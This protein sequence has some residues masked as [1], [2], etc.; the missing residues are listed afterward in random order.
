MAK[1]MI[2]RRCEAER[3]R[4]DRYE[5]TLR[6]AQRAPRP[7]PD[8]AR[9]LR[10]SA[11]GFAGILARDP[12]AWRPKL[13][14]RDPARLRL[15][16]ARHLFALYSVPYALE[17]I[18]LDGSGLDA[19][20]ITLRRRWYVVAARG[21][22]LWKEEAKEWLSRKEVHW[23][24][25][26][27]G[28]LGFD[29][30]IWLAVAR[31]YTEDIGV[32]LR[33]ARSKIARTPRA[34]FAFWREVTRFFCA[35]PATVAE[36]DDLCDYLAAR[37]EREPDYSVAGR[38]L[39][40][41]HRQMLEWHRDLD[42]IARIEA[43]R[44]RAFRTREGEDDGRWS[45]SPLDDWSWKPTAGE[46]RLRKEQFAVTQLVTADE[47]VAESRAMHHCVSSYAQKCVSG[48]A[49]I[50]SLRRSAAGSVKRLLT[51]ELDRQHRA[52]QIRG[53][54]NR[55]ASAEELQVLGR[56]AKAMGVVLP[57]H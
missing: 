36:I 44:R 6:R 34:G 10:E 5:A 55:L 27:S 3:E 25:N 42:A 43:A 40:S 24:L 33:I 31:S 50:W 23:F 13:K 28:E 35:S 26:S 49:S 17:E 29:E 9:A 52:V 48:Q 47:L 21:R 38:T 18:W 14:T 8:F 30:A 37:H 16:A 15:A 41:L 12:E 11:H 46:A 4:I 57:E 1:S 32:A 19:A 45:G 51:I 53:F 39:A 54:G 56:W 2:K 20:E 7:A 22:S